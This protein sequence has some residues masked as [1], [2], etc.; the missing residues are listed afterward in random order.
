MRTTVRIIS[1]ATEPSAFFISSRR[2]G[3]NCILFLQLLDLLQTADVI[4]LL[5]SADTVPHRR[6][7]SGFFDFPQDFEDDFGGRVYRMGV[8]AYGLKAERFKLWQRKMGNHAA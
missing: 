8:K 2:I 3:S 1:S 6:G 5:E 7:V 4:E